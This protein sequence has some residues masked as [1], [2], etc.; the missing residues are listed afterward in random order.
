MIIFQP[1]FLSQSLPESLETLKV[2][3]RHREGSRRALVVGPETRPDTRQKFEERGNERGWKAEGKK[4]IIPESMREHTHRERA[5][6]AECARSI[7]E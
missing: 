4:E 7:V 3:E 2:G 6:D 5:F 1:W